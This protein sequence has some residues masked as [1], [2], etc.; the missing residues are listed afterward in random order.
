MKPHFLYAK[1]MSDQSRYLWIIHKAVKKLLYIRTLWILE[2]LK[3]CTQNYF[4]FFLFKV[5]S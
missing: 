2:E 5:R 4:Q 1:G 3:A